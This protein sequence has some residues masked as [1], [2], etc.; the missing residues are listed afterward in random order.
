MQFVL[1]QHE[2]YPPPTAGYLCIT[3]GANSLLL[4]EALP[5]TNSD[6]T[7]FCNT[8]YILYSY[9]KAREKKILSK[10]EHTVLYLSEKNPHE[11]DLRS[12][13]CCS[14]VNCN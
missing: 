9:N 6:L 13:R 1:E 2:G 3:F 14:K 5:I 12:N 8:Y 7:R 4:T 11:V 10:S